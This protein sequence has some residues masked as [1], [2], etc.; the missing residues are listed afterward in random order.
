[1]S[2]QRLGT[3][4]VNAAPLASTAT[5]FADTAAGLGTHSYVV[6]AVARALDILDLLESASGAMSL[7][8]LADAVDLPKSSVFRYLSTLYNREWLE[9]RGLPVFDW[10]R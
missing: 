8:Y 9:A 2:W 6:R 1:M 7:A 4:K 5:T 3:T 10:L